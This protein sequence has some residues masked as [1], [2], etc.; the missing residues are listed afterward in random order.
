M[1]RPFIILLHLAFWGG[2]F[3]LLLIML[4]IY[5]KDDLSKIQL[6]YHVQ[7]LSSF[8]LIPSLVAFY[9]SYF[10]I[11]PQYLKHKKLPLTFFYVAITIVLSVLLGVLSL[12]YTKEL[13][14]A[15]GPCYQS[16][17]DGL[18]IMATIALVCSIVAIILKGCLTW[19]EE[20]QLKDLLQQK[21]YEMELA[22]LKAQ[23]DPHFLFNTIN[24]I[25]ILILKDASKASQ[26]LHQLSTL[27]RFMLFETK[28]DFI[29]LSKEVEYINKYIALQ[30]IRTSNLNYVTYNLQ[31]KIT[32]QLI[33]PMIFIPFIE[34][35]FKHSHNKKIPNAIVIKILVTT[36]NIQLYCENKYSPYRKKADAF[37]GLG[38]QLIQKR[39]H[40]I[41]P[42]KHQLV[43]NK[44]DKS[45]KVHLT[46]HHHASI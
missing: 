28:A 2:Y 33:A 19:I 42:Q 24:N 37:N 31:G 22:L 30:K 4:G 15:W 5:F 21:N 6:P 23:L 17:V 41:Y 10:F 20:R 18:F 7:V 12:S 26:Y 32:N 39:L 13:Y 43:I 38:N 36:E 9:L 44:D 11:F 1:K 40:L 14:W 25:D 16:D 27:I 35:A 29:P 3:F 8:V 45:Y 34:N 46:I